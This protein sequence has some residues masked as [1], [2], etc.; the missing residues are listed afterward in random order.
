VID[1][2]LELTDALRKA[3]V[4]V[5][6]SESLDTLRA[7]E[8]VP[9]EDREA[10]RATLAATMIKSEAHRPAFDALFDI[11]LGSGPP[12]TTDEESRAEVQN[13]PEDFRE[14]L[15]DAIA[16][17]DGAA[18]RMLAE[19]AV[20][21]FGRVE[22]S[23]SGSL[24]FQYPV[25][26]AVDLDALLERLMDEP[27]ASDMERRLRRAEFEERVSLFR[28]IVAREVNRRVAERRGP[29]T[30]IRTAVR[31]LPEVLDFSTATA[32][33]IAQL[34]RSI[35]PLARRLATRVAMK[36]RRASRGGLD[37]RRTVRHS[38][39]TGGA[40]F[41]LEFRHRPPHRP[42]LFVLCDISSSVASFSR[43]SLMLVHA[44]SAQ[45]TRVRS[46]AFIDTIDE[47]TRLFEH[48]DFMRAVDRM[49]KEAR[50]VWIDGHSNYGASL[51]K[52][53]ETYGK[54]LNAKSTLLV[55]GDARTNF[56]PPKSW[57]LKELR[58]RAHRTYWLNP[59]AEIYWDTGD[60]VASE[61]AAVVDDM[62]EVRNL[63]QLESFIETVI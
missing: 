8:H 27:V 56:R 49:N 12:D 22:D 42:E 2:L 18:I 50:V 28:E 25:F 58:D 60:S 23:P 52:F 3:G 5:A 59:E 57:A 47:V 24:Y 13:S 15:A 48:E 53:T 16:S 36:R 14:Q 26:R 11:Y 51:E 9:I 21:T 17:G 20:L 41:D 30:V 10:V 4:P 31:P 55:L 63:K 7:L 6:V 1:R 39:S 45:F 19:R 37:M 29:E 44:L 46:F 54:D 33:E 38:L 32:A 35:R 62:V 43:F 40:P 34:R 61:Y